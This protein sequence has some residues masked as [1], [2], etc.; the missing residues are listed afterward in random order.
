MT[1]KQIIN[2]KQAIEDNVDL[3]DGYEDLD[4]DIQEKIKKSLEDGHIPDDEWIG[5]SLLNDIAG[6][7]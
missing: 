7:H 4:E 5:V 1:P 2:L 3:L 6:T